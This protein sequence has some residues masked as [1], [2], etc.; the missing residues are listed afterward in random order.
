MGLFG[1]LG[2]GLAGTRGW[3]GRLSGHV[4][5][6]R[7]RRAEGNAGPGEGYQSD[8]DHPHCEGLTE[9]TPLAYRAQRHCE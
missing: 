5:A 7:D 1:A 3:Q 9:R 8:V 6:R 2:L 4:A